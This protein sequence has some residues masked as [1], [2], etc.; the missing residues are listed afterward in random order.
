MMA[1]L[2]ER[3]GAAQNSEAAL[4]I[5]ADALDQDEQHLESLENRLQSLGPDGAGY[6]PRSLAAR[7]ADGLNP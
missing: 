2:A 6:L 7:I 1:S 4:K 3:I 5:I